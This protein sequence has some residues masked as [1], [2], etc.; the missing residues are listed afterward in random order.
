MTSAQMSVSFTAAGRKWSMPIAGL[1]TTRARGRLML[2]T[3]QYH[4]DTDT[5]PRGTEWVI[6]GRPPRVTAVRRNEGRTPTPRDGSVLSY[7]GLRLPET[8]RA[9]MPGVEVGFEVAWKFVNGASASISTRPTPSSPV[10][11]C[12]A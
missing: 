11:A 10:R 2:Y 1:N 4:A 6:S 7:G 5:A 8:L 12:C 9:L 3:P